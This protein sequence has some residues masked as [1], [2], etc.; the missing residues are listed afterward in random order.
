M[1][2]T[3]SFYLKPIQGLEKWGLEELAKLFSVGYRRRDGFGFTS[4][5]LRRP[6]IHATLIYKSVFSHKIYNPRRRRLTSQEQITFYEVPF[7]VDY[8]SGLLAAYAGGKKLQRLISVIAQLLK[9]EIT[10]QDLFIDIGKVLEDLDARGQSYRVARLTID[11]FQPQ[12]GMSG[13]IDA[14]IAEPKIAKRLINQ[15]GKD[16]TEI[17]LEMS[18]SDEPSIW[19]F[20]STGRIAVT[21]DEDLL[22]D[23][24]FPVPAGIIIFFDQNH[25]VFLSGSRGL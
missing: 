25:S 15:Y 8:D 5:E 2:R 24:D 21:V 6:V 9:F 17:T 13:R 23:V 4:L 22:Q 12:A 11:N 1:Y 14:V 19:R 7:F 20:T 18:T 16:V 10:I 3:Q